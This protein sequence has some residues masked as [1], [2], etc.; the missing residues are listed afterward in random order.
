MKIRL[1]II[2][3]LLGYSITAASSSWAADQTH[4]FIEKASIGGQFEISSSRLALQNSQNPDIKNFAQKMIDDHTK[5]SSQLKSII[6]S[7]NPD[8]SQPTIA[9]D[10]QHQK[11]LNELNGVKGANF[12]RLYVHDQVAAHKEAVNLFRNYSRNG[13]NDAIKNFAIQNLPTLEHHQSDVME[14]RKDL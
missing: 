12:D 9:L 13:D 5:I 10:N 14:L 7:A 11:M 1:Y 2:A 4:K 8:E 3:G 6:T